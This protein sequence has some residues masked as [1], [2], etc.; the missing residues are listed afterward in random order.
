MNIINPNISLEEAEKGFA[1]LMTDEQAK[2]AYDV[3]VPDH[4]AQGRG[5]D[6]RSLAF[7]NRVL[8]LHGPVNE[9]S[10]NLLCMQLQYLCVPAS[11]KQE[12]RERRIL[13]YVSSPGG[14]VWDGLLFMEYIRQVREATNEPVYVIDQSFAASMGS[15]ITQA[16]SPGCRMGFIS[17]IH[18]IHESA[19]GKQGKTSTHAEEVGFTAKLEVQLWREYERAILDNR[20]LFFG[21]DIND[22]KLR[23]QVRYFLM[24]QVKRRDTFLT[25]SQAQEYSLLDFVIPSN[26]LQVKYYHAMEVY[27][28]LINPETNKPCD[29]WEG[30]SQPFTFAEQKLTD[31]DVE[32]Q[33]ALGLKLLRELRD[34]SAAF[35]AQRKKE[36]DPWTEIL[37]QLDRAS[38]RAGNGISADIG[39]RIESIFL[40]EGL[41]AEDLNGASSPFYVPPGSD[42]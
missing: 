23:A 5:Y 14:S 40:K 27:L 13:I 24:T 8:Y 17:T 38:Y 42:E 16:A 30:Q 26:T 22:P 33:K 25:A 3:M 34:Q 21:D 20:Q 7:R 10:M 39:K 36:T 35:C 15:A 19:Y 28:G 2:G 9:H 29:L 6:L 37:E 1:A 41:S 4:D 32:K 31:E 11:L 12:R 18:M